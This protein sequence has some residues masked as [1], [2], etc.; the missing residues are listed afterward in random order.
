MWIKEI[1]F[2]KLSSGLY[3]VMYFFFVL[4]LFSRYIFFPIFQQ[5]GQNAN[6]RLFKFLRLAF[7][8]IL[9][10]IDF[11]ECTIPFILDFCPSLLQKKEGKIP[12]KKMCLTKRKLLSSGLQASCNSRLRYDFMFYCQFSRF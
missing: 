2:T 8:T 10:E 11:Y 6:G 1:K 12:W 7:Y 9:H 3:Y 5:Q 4:F